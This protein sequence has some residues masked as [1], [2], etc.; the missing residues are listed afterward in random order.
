MLLLAI[1][2]R[3]R[4]GIEF[5]AIFADTGNEH[6][7]TIDYVSGLA[8][9]VGGPAI[10]W[11]KADFADRIAKKRAH[12]EQSEEYP[13]STKRRILECLHPTGNPFLDLCLWKG[14]FPSPKA[15]FCTVELKVIPAREQYIDPLLDAGA[16][17][18][19]W[20]GVRADESLKRSR[21]ARR[22]LDDVNLWIFRPILRRTADWA[23]SMHRRH[24]CQPNPLYSLGARRVG[25]SPCIMCAK[26]ELYQ[27]VTRFPDQIDKIR[28]WEALMRQASKRGI[29]TFFPCKTIPG[30]APDRAHIDAVASWSRTLRGGRQFDLL[31]MIP[32]PACQSEYGLC[33]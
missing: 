18:E 12:I 21:L 27:I 26:A 3:D 32:P 9:R 10:K 11:V 24:G 28:E 15:R 8:D 23:F 4:W 16:T 13:D 25:C 19:S 30:K 6:S 1:E 20:Q 17:V 22:S 31:K 29:S 33:E 14:R 5:E 7:A 2:L